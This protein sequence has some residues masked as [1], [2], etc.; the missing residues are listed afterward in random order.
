VN[1]ADDRDMNK[2]TRDKNVGFND[3][4]SQRPADVAQRRHRA[5]RKEEKV[6]RLGL[7]PALKS[8]DI[9][10]SVADA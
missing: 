5:V 2:V 9:G 6:S 10:K 1:V 4:P 8:S 3:A 7:F